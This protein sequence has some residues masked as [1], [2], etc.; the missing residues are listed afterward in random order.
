MAASEYV[1]LSLRTGSFRGRFDGQMVLVVIAVGAGACVS[2]TSCPPGATQ[3]ARRGCLLSTVPTGSRVA[4][5][6]WGKRNDCSEETKR[7][8]N[9]RMWDDW[10]KKFGRRIVIGRQK[11]VKY[12][13]HSSV[14]LWHTSKHEEVQSR[15][16]ALEPSTIPG[17]TAAVHIVFHCVL[18]FCFQHFLTTNVKRE[19]D[20]SYSMEGV[21]Q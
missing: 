11:A 21:E 5:V 17:F 19:K 6:P 18:L 15:N 2:G 16:I 7:G 14:N 1:C 10:W 4:P 8:K 12:I 20:R 9:E 13:F 3:G